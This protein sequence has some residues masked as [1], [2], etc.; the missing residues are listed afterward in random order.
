M[1][2]IQSV[3][4]T[5]ASRS[6]RRWRWMGNLRRKDS[7]HPTTEDPIIWAYVQA[8]GDPERPAAEMAQLARSGLDRGGTPFI[9]DGSFI[10]ARR[11]IVVSPG[12]V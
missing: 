1:L 10:R 5:M 12:S 11:Q 3:A 9:I 6:T 2:A 4:G 8:I 7:E